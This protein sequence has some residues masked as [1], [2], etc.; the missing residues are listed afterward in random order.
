MSCCCTDTPYDQSDG[1]TPQPESRPGSKLVPTV[2][3]PPNARLSIWP[4][5][6]TLPVVVG[7]CANGLWRLQS[8]TKLWLLSVHVRPVDGAKMPPKV[9]VPFGIRSAGLA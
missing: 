9:V 5:L 7:P 1:R 3:M 4:Q 8:G 6:S 2:W